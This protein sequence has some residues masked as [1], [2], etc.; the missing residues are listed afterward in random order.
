MLPNLYKTIAVVIFSVELP[1]V[2]LYGLLCL[3]DYPYQWHK[4]K[5]RSMAFILE[6]IERGKMPRKWL[7][8]DWEHP[9]VSLLMRYAQFRI[10]HGYKPNAR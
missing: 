4:R 8:W 7:D 9:I 5:L 2:L 10:K 6:Q 3:L 1:I